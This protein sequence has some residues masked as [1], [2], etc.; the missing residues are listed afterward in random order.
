MMKLAA[1]PAYHRIL[2]PKDED[3]VIDLSGMARTG[4]L[5]IVGD[6]GNVTVQNGD[7]CGW[8]LNVSGQIKRLDLINLRSDVSRGDARDVVDIAGKIE[9]MVADRCRFTGVKGQGGGIHGDCIQVFDTA[10]VGLLMIRRSTLHSA[11][12][13]VMAKLRDDGV[14]VKRIILQDT[15]IRDYS[16]ARVQQ[17]VAVLLMGCQSKQASVE[18]RNAWIEWPKAAT[19]AI[20]TAGKVQ[21]SGAFNIGIPHG[22]D[23]CPA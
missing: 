23:F 19:H 18:L 16:E 1:R 5:D 20:A 22:G 11:Y 3:A 6:G 21:R 10:S 14:G 9:T 12:Q 17:S 7:L 8:R 13:A 15:N 2:C 4:G